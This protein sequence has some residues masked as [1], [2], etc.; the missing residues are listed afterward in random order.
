MLPLLPVFAALAGTTL[1]LPN[2]QTGD[3]QPT[4]RILPYTWN[5]NI[6]ALS[7]PGCP[8]F[9]STAPIHVTR[10]TF[11][12]NTMDGS[13]IYY[14]HFAYPHLRAS[15]GPGNPQA[16]VWC[17]TTLDYAEMDSAGNA[18]AGYRLK[19]HKN[20]TKVMALYDLDEGVE[21][22]WTFTYYPVKNDKVVDSI[23]VAGPRSAGASDS[24]D[25]SPANGSA[26]WALPDCGAGTIKYRTELVL[27]A[28]KEGARGTVESLKIKYTNQPESG[29]YGVQQGI[30]YDWEKCAA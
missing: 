18:A 25:I 23:T 8:D 4:V 16:S 6:T 3:D 14:W 15:V 2:P 29:Y 10:P 28:K 19:L 1:G 9:G 7:G 22:Q 26:R 11:G 21:A 24:V 13:E 30:S 20:G 5:F 12:S 27:K 17:E